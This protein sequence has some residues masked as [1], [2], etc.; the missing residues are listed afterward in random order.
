MRSYKTLSASVIIL[1]IQL[2]PIASY[3]GFEPWEI[4]KEVSP[5]SVG[6]ITI[7]G[8]DDLIEKS[9]AYG[10][11][12]SGSETDPFLISDII[13]ETGGNLTGLH[14][15]STGSHIVLESITVMNASGQG[16]SVSP[17]AGIDI[18]GSRNITIRK[19]DLT[20]NTVGLWIEGSAS[21]D[22]RNTSAENCTT[23][24]VLRSCSGIDVRDCELHYNSAYG[25][26]LFGSHHCNI[27]N[28]RAFHNDLGMDLTVSNNNRIFHNNCSWNDDH[29]VRLSGS[30]NNT[31]EN[32][33]MIG[34]DDGVH[35]LS[36]RYHNVSYNIIRDQVEYGI[37]LEMTRSNSI[38]HNSMFGCSFMLIGDE[39]TFTDQMLNN[40]TVN[41]LKVHYFKGPLQ[42]GIDVRGEVGQII[43]ADV[44]NVAF[45]DLSVSGGSNGITIAYSTNCSVLN[46]TIEDMTYS[47]IYLK[48][49]TIVEMF[50]MGFRDIFEGVAADNSQYITIGASYFEN[51]TWGVTFQG[52]LFSDISDNVFS[53]GDHGIRLVVSRENNLTDNQFFMLEGTG[54][55]LTESSFANLITGNR[56]NSC[57]LGMDLHLSPYTTIKDNRIIFVKD[58]IILKSKSCTLRNNSIKEFDDVGV[59]ISEDF[60]D[61]IHNLLHSDT[62]TGI[63]IMSG[64]NT[65]IKNRIEM[66]YKTGIYIATQ[67]RN[68]FLSNNL[69]GCNFDLLGTESWK[70]EIPENNTVNGLP[71]LFLKSQD[72]RNYDPPSSVGQIMAVDCQNL[73][74]ED[75]SMSGIP[76]FI[77]IQDCENVTIRGASTESITYPVEVVRSYNV[78]I[79][80]CS[81]KGGRTQINIL[82]EAVNVRITNSIF[83]SP[84]SMGIDIQHLQGGG[85]EGCEF[86]GSGG[87]V[88]VDNVLDIILKK[89]FFHD[90]DEG[91]TMDSYSDSVT[92]TGNIFRDIKGYDIIFKGHHLSCRVQGNCFIEGENISMEEGGPVF[93]NNYYDDPENTKDRDGDEISDVPYPISGNLTRD[94][95]PL[96]VLPMS[97][98]EPP[99]IRLEQGEPPNV[100]VDISARGLDFGL[101]NM[102]VEIYNETGEV[103]LKTDKLNGNASFPVDSEGRD[104]RFNARTITELGNSMLSEERGLILDWNPP[105]IEFTFPNEGA[106]LNESGVIIRWK[107]HDNASSIEGVNISVDGGKPVELG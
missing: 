92:I 89:C 40:N 60:N 6:S 58:G 80:G 50:D 63:M 99:V 91:I 24:A 71:V 76:S 46:T 25:I 100:S 42:N 31:V 1:L 103:V 59:R 55:V 94:L 62:G 78:K 77:Y 23:G 22:I 11:P 93:V 8:D 49:S 88:V 20:K 16:N 86:R 66:N 68:H 36:G 2:S 107:L 106:L 4:T 12:G 39:G 82:N 7:S 30:L 21:I 52:C 67:E 84:S 98:V 28:S 18:R 73:V 32:N 9:I 104:Y 75:Q 38:H 48:D 34:N 79:D 56:L 47:G 45:G 35:I 61:L 69:T 29:G 27:S 51:L 101:E 105:E 87:A 14:I 70:Q 85:I 17:G 44:H 102:G 54:I 97:V 13:L 64:R 3:D 33:T 90:L 37:Y 83:E 10:W 81:F 57:G 65:L 26:R 5:P 15:D 41:G 95:Y 96:T 72:L 19:C 74:M 53:F 43:A